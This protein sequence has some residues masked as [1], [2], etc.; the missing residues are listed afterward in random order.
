[1]HGQI[2][3]SRRSNIEEPAVSFPSG[4]RW[5]VVRTNIRCEQRANH[6]LAAAGFRAFLPQIT[7]WRTHARLRTITAA[8]LFPRYLFLEADFNLQPITAVHEADG[9]ESIINNCL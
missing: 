2:A 8:P 7:K 6:G 5:Y 1:M 4:L 9:V 3:M